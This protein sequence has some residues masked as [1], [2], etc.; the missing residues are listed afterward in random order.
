MAARFSRHLV[1]VRAAS[2][3][4]LVPVMA[5]AVAAAMGGPPPSNNLAQ[6]VLVRWVDGASSSGNGG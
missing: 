3:E 6:E 5:S 2:S 1:M 4:A